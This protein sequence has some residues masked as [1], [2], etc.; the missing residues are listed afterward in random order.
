MVRDEFRVNGVLNVEVDEYKLSVPIYPVIDRQNLMYVRARIAA[1]LPLVP[2]KGSNLRI[3]PNYIVFNDLNWL[4]DSEKTCMCTTVPTIIKQGRAFLGSESG[5]TF[6]DSPKSVFVTHLSLI[7]HYYTDP[8]DANHAELSGLITTYVHSLETTSL[9]KDPL[10]PRFKELL[11]D[12]MYLDFFVKMIRYVPAPTSHESQTLMDVLSRYAELIGHPADIVRRAT[13]ESET[14]MLNLYESAKR[15]LRQLESYDRMARDLQVPSVQVS[16]SIDLGH[17][18]AI[19]HRY[20]DP[21]LVFDSIPASH[22]IPVIMYVRP[23]EK[24]LYKVYTRTEVPDAWYDAPQRVDEHHIN[25]DNAV[26]IL[27]ASVEPLQ[28]PMTRELVDDDKYIPIVI[29]FTDEITIYVA[30]DDPLALVH[31]HLPSLTHETGI[32]DL[33]VKKRV[34][35]NGISLNRRLL[36]HYIQ[37]DPSASQYFYIDETSKPITMKKHRFFVYFAPPNTKRHTV[38]ANLLYDKGKT[39]PSTMGG[40][41]AYESARDSDYDK[42]IVSCTVLESGDFEPFVTLLG[43]VLRRYQRLE[44]ELRKLYPGVDLADVW[45][46]VTP[47]STELS[48]LREL[49][50][51]EPELFGSTRYGSGCTNKPAYIDESDVGHTIDE[52]GVQWYRKS[53]KAPVLK[54]KFRDGQYRY[55]VCRKTGLNPYLYQNRKKRNEHPVPCCRAGDSKATK[56]EGNENEKYILAGNEVLRYRRVATF[57]NYYTLVGRLFDTMRIARYG[58]IWRSKFTFVDT[59]IR[60][61]HYLMTGHEVHESDVRNA[62]HIMSIRARMTEYI[63]AGRQSLYDFSDEEVRQIILHDTNNPLDSEYFVCVA[64]EMYNCNIIV[65]TDGRKTRRDPI[66]ITLEIPH[67]KYFY[68]RNRPS[69]DRKTIVV[70]RH[71]GASGDTDIE[72]PVYEPL[73]DIKSTTGKKGN[74]VGTRPEEWIRQFD[75]DHGD[76]V[77][78]NLLYERMLHTHVSGKVFDTVVDNIQGVMRVD[79]QYID[80][81]G[82]V[83]MVVVDGVHIR[84]SPIPPMAKVP[85]LDS[86]DSKPCHSAQVEERIARYGI[87]GLSRTVK[88]GQTHTV[89]GMLKGVRLTFETAGGFEHLPV[90]EPVMASGSDS[91]STLDSYRRM[92]KNARL[93]QQYF[94]YAYSVWVADKSPDDGDLVARFIREGTVISPIDYNAVNYDRQFHHNNLFD[95]RKRFIID[96]PLL[97][98]KLVYML[99]LIAHDTKFV[100]RYRSA[101]LKHTFLYTHDY[102]RTPGGLIIESRDGINAWLRTRDTDK[103]LYEGPPHHNDS[104]PWFFASFHHNNGQLYLIQN[105]DPDVFYVKGPG[106]SFTEKRPIR[107]PSDRTTREVEYTFRTVSALGIAG[108][109][110]NNGFNSGARPALLNEVERRDYRRVKVLDECT[111]QT[112]E[113]KVESE[114]PFE[115]I[116]YDHGG[117]RQ[118]GAMLPFE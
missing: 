23:L 51:L 4:N 104:D 47:E 79:G 59:F 48:D 26:I 81:S 99:R 74:V 98:Y 89:S 62:H 8:Q 39:P 46:E 17:L 29:E 100:D 28:V 85:I 75:T 10:H 113:S 54:Y 71:M 102:K 65:L 45:N 93:I 53:D 36:T 112:D 12:E 6:P 84:T 72:V 58:I 69:R 61:V 86:M 96:N 110:R 55:Y 27:Y 109:W 42:L 40:S 80:S 49:R 57:D 94:M 95:E 73:V 19:T 35:F 30:G 68:V 9:E 33:N 18:K 118:V 115:L 108:F 67:H 83:Q 21:H 52:N 3:P 22:D 16:D 15:T 24:T 101:S 97:R 88:S 82:R 60:C 87:E 78:L 117:E 63:T 25:Y 90:K 41:I 20:E 5:D 107:G 50:R 111:V 14:Y 11:T 91:G 66:D 76:I 56:L 106:R 31:R 34:I 37:L 2:Y 1:K 92:K 44:S 13:E 43:R 70:F 105:P 103:V 38:V 77:K 7:Q 64:E 32:R 116:E 114:S